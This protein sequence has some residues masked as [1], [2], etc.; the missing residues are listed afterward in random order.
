MAH[1]NLVGDN[2]GDYLLICNMILCRLQS[3][4]DVFDWKEGIPL[5]QVCE[6]QLIIR[7]WELSRFGDPP[8]D[9]PVFRN[10]LR[11]L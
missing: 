7:I 11:I 2:L 1:H 3:I 5:A 9:C 4:G 6:V 10:L 8:R